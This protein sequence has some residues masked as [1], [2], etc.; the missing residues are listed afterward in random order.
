MYNNDYSIYIALYALKG[1][2]L[3]SHKEGKSGRMLNFTNLS[4][5]EAMNSDYG[6][7]GFNTTIDNVLDLML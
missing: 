2:S 4:V 5:A 1:K 3:L 7:V 6:R